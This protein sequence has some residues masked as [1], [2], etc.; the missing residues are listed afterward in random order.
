M[1]WVLC[2]IFHRRSISPKRGND[3]EDSLIREYSPYEYG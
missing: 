3:V 2:Y 1:G